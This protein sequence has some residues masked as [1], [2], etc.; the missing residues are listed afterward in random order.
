[1]PAKPSRQRDKQKAVVWTAIDQYRIIAVG[2]LRTNLKKERFTMEKSVPKVYPVGYSLYG[3][4]DYVERLMSDPQMRLI[5]IR[6][7]PYSWRPDW[8]ADRLQAKYGERYRQGGKY[9][10]NLNYRNKWP[11]QIADLSTGIT[12]LIQY[13]NEGHDLILL[14]QC[15]AY[16]DCHRKVIVEQLKQAMPEVEA[17]LPG[18]MRAEVISHA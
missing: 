8:Q 2:G 10:G 6:L 12:G 18:R 4:E 9:L 14:C 15:A 11:I 13:L 3:S 7:V 17:V 1:L 5:D 16:D